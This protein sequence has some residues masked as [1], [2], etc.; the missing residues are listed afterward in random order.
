[1]HF[2]KDAKVLSDQLK[3]IHCNVIRSGESQRKIMKWEYYLCCFHILVNVSANDP[4]FVYYN[5]HS[6]REQLNHP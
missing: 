6:D 3:D 1:M 5:S 4:A 2:S